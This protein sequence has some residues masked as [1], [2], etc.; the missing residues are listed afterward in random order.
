MTPEQRN[1]AEHALISFA[2]KISDLAT[3]EAAQFVDLSSFPPER[4]E[5]ERRRLA[6]MMADF[7][8][9]NVHIT[10][11]A[12]QIGPELAKESGKDI[13]EEVY[14]EAKHQ[15]KAAAERFSRKHIFVRPGQ[16]GVDQKAVDDLR[17]SIARM[18]TQFGVKS[19]VPMFD[20]LHDTNRDF[21]D[22]IAR[23]AEA[24]KRR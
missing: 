21:P 23:A 17:D 1:V 8:M 20:V 18:L 6:K 15:F 24:R 22:V 2:A 16:E 9:K 7:V 5:G 4:R 14:L 11:N 3:I 19:L 10:Q 13:A 12:I